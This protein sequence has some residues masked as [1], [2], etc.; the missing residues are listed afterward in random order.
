MADMTPANGQEIPTPTVADFKAMIAKAK[1]YRDAQKRLRGMFSAFQVNVAT[2]TVALLAQQLGDRIDLQRIWNSQSV[3]T[4]LMN[5]I[6]V[7]SREVND[8]LHLSANSRMVSE[9]AKR[10]EC[11]IAVLGAQYSSSA[12]NIPEVK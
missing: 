1:I 6:A 12:S 3:S 5:Q 11:K 7:W 10:P 4:E 9:W 2:Y 8:T